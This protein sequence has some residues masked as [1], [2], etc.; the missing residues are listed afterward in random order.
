MTMKNEVSASPDEAAIAAEVSANNAAE[1]QPKEG[2]EEQSAPEPT[3][4]V[5][6]QDLE[7]AL[8]RVE[9]T[10]IG[11]N[12][13]WNAQQMAQIKTSVQS[14]LDE[15][16]APIRDMASKIEQRQVEEMEPE[17]QVEYWK[18]KASTPAP[19]PTPQP[20]QQQQVEWS[21]GDRL[22]IATEVQ[23]YADANKV[24]VSYLD[25]KVWQNTTTAMPVDQLIQI[26]KQNIDGMKGATPT[27]Q[28]PPVQAQAATPT[29][30][31]STQG[32]SEGGSVTYGSRTEANQAL[33]NGD[34]ANIDEWTAIGKAEGWLK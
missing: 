24:G 4:G 11:R 29:P 19:A 23:Q 22:R 21:D 20:Q 32:A 13:N 5:T 16:L 15:A 10:V 8:S 6:L 2:T 31:P 9:K 26:A 12:N 34:I 18:K 25:S 3:Q 28:A 27:P 14:Q 30:P 17:E 33:L 7:N 1:Q